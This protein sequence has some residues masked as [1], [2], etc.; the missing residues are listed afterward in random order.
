MNHRRSWHYAS[1]ATLW[2][3]L[4]ASQA[5]AQTAQTPAPISNSAA[6]APSLSICSACIRAHLEFLAGDA[7]QGRGSGTHDELLAATYV[8]SEL[9]AYEIEP[10]GDNGGYLEEITVIRQSFTKPPTLT[11]ALADKS[12]SGHVITWTHGQQ[13]LVID[14]TQT[15]FSGS[16]QKIDADVGQSKLQP[17]AV[18]FLSGKDE[19]KLAEVAWSLASQGALAVLIP[20]STEQQDNWADLGQKNPE[21]R[22]QL[23][24][25]GQNRRKKNLNILALNHEAETALKNAA[26]GTPVH[27]KGTGSA[28]EKSKTWNAIG[29]VRGQDKALQNSAVLL[30]AHIDHLG[31]GPPVN[32]DRIYNGADDDASGVAAVLEFARLLGEQPPKQT[33]ILA[34]FG[35]EEVGDLGS[36]YFAENPPVPLSAISAALEFEMIGRRDPALSDN[37]LWLSGW[38]RSNL[39]PELVSHGANIVG[40]P[41]VEQGFFQRSD[42][43]ALAERGVVAQTISSF[44]LHSDYHKPSDDLA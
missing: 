19:R 43:Y 34:F 33:L 23:E 30:S 12:A 22:P 35:S 3:A 7:L 9:R 25:R 42:N 26:D 41:H 8:A 32:G 18:V 44:G 38:D 21:L 29:I 39:G 24:G 36:T 11:I 13:M 15:E 17:G 28:A 5:A 37:K 14:A 10:A 27:F 31:I 20:A 16:L 40:D 4:L 6:V 2:A 1:T